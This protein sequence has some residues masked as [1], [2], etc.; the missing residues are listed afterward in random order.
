MKILTLV[1]STNACDYHR[2]V[3]P[4]RFL[5]LEDRESLKIIEHDQQVSAMAFKN[6]D[7]VV[8]NR[9]PPFDLDHILSLRDRFKFKIWVD[10]DDYWKLYPG[11]YL[12]AHWKRDKTEQKII[13]ALSIADIVTVT[14]RRLLR[15]VLPIN[16]K[17]RII[18]NAIPIG[19]DQFLSQKQESTTV[20]FMYAGGPSHGKD[21]KSIEKFFTL[22]GKNACTYK[23]VEFILAGYSDRY[24]EPALHEMND[25]MSRAPNYSTLL[26]LPV[27]KYMNH[28]NFADVCLSP[29]IKNE[30][31]EMKSNLKIIE[32]GCMRCP[33]ICTNMFPFL[34][35]EKMRA[36]GVFY[37]NNAADW[38]D[39]CT[40]L[41]KNP[42]LIVEYGNQLYDY[43][44][45]H[46]DLLEINK[47]RREIINSF[48]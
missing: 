36:K 3:N 42:N 41:I 32:A 30:F 17:A 5:P 43:V 20:R 45:E 16:E 4:F 24:K 39:V 38:N 10:I 26:G 19:F 7:L 11:H 9:Y 25:I 48:K 27:N 23:N 14:N 44:K 8:F 40:Y 31:N 47:I 37:C 46:Y 28:Y 35:D 2:V 21:L 6:A 1:T 29:L 18:P 15:A 13:K 34:E 33:I 12:E 22:M